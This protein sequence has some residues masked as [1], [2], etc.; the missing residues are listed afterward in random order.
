[1]SAS[2]GFNLLKFPKDVVLAFGSFLSHEDLSGFMKAATAP[3]NP[4]G[5][6]QTRLWLTVT[7]ILLLGRFS[8]V[9]LP[10]R[11]SNI[12]EEEL[13]CWKAL[14]DEETSALVA[15]NIQSFGTIALLFQ[16]SGIA[17]RISSELGGNTHK[18]T[19]QMVWPMG[20][21]CCPEGG[22]G[23]HPWPPVVFS[24]P[25]FSTSTL[26]W[27]G[28]AM[29]KQMSQGLMM[30]GAFGPLKLIREKVRPDENMGI[31][32]WHDNDEEYFDPR[33]RDPT[34]EDYQLFLS[35]QMFLTFSNE[36]ANTKRNLLWQPYRALAQ[37]P[38]REIMLQKLQE[39][40]DCSWLSQATMETATIP[41][42]HTVCFWIEE[43]ETP[44]VDEQE[45]SRRA[46]HD[47]D[48]VVVARIRTLVNQLTVVS[49]LAIDTSVCV[50]E[51]KLTKLQDEGNEA[52]G[53]PFVD[54]LGEG[55][56]VLKIG[57]CRSNSTSTDDER[58]AMSI[59]IGNSMST[60]L[61]FLNQKQASRETMEEQI[62]SIACHSVHVG[63][64]SSTRMFCP[65]LNEL[66]ECVRK[67]LHL[68]HLLEV[69]QDDSGN[70]KRLVLGCGD[71][72]SHS[73]LT[74]CQISS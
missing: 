19:N 71:V 21:G 26:S 23:E 20:C 48:E 70:E 35:H 55:S 42:K 12:V 36:A 6:Q 51:W 58:V 33:Q 65:S 4:Q 43:K 1:M 39:S 49:R 59:K 62:K 52:K 8:S 56:F 63:G 54:L 34:C 53:F 9:V 30:D 72:G 37:H 10:T 73:G 13:H 27:A 44:Q 16:Y 22:Y 60:T 46:R 68:T 45:G 18:D 14:R 47:D 41:N 24:T 3:A 38:V 69:L 50:G 40:P 74:F 66:E 29:P 11:L 31:L 64:V 25:R 61:T 32:T 28:E 7:R 57:R 2:C 17:V 5:D 15:R 67:M